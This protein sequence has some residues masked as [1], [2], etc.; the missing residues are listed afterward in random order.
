[1]NGAPLTAAHGAPLR[2]VV[3]RSY[4]MDSVKW[5][6]R[7]RLLDR[8][9]EGHFQVND[10]R[11]FPPAGSTAP[12]LPIGPIRVNSLIAWPHDGAAV[13]VGEEVRVAGYAWSGSGGV[14]RVEVSVDSGREWRAA[15]LV[16]LEAPHAWRLWEM[17]WTPRAAGRFAVVGGRSTAPEARSPWRRPGTPKVMPIT[18]GTG[19]RFTSADT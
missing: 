9:F 16:G 3:P 14:E 8:A 18:G 1:M 15:A 11:L 10:Y 17:S 4:G 7:L 13:R 12:A 2:A 19:S 5:L 6:V